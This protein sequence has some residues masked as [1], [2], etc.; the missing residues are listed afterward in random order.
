MHDESVYPYTYLH[1][2][3]DTLEEYQKDQK[4]FTKIKS[5]N[6]AILYAG[7][8][9]GALKPSLAVEALKRNVPRLID[10][11]YGNLPEEL[12]QTFL[13]HRYEFKKL[14]LNIDYLSQGCL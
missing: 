6:R 1:E 8:A 9:Y 7:F 13:D 4:D 11:Q 5:R 10:N 2:V 14:G 3:K 12:I